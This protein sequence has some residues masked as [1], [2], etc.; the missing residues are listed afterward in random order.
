[1]HD[2][3]HHALEAMPAGGEELEGVERLTLRSVGIDIGSSTTHAGF[4]E[5]TLRREGRHSARFIVAG[6]RELYRSPII[7]TPYLSGTRIDAESVITFVAGCYRAA[8]IAPDAVDTGA[9]VITGEALKKEN[10]RPILEH[11]AREGGRFVCASAGPMHEA[12]LAAHGSGAVAL[13]RHHRNAVLNVDIG[14]GTTK[15]S[16]VRAGRIERMMAIEIGA[17]LVAFDADMRITRL[18]QPGRTILAALG[19]AAEVG[20]S[21]APQQGR[22]LAEKMADLLFEAIIG[23]R[24]DA[25]AEQLMLSDSQ[26]GRPIGGIDHLVFSGG[27]AEYVY[28]RE[29]ESFGDLGPWLGA[30]LRD[31]AR[32]RLAQGVL[33]GATEGIRATVIGAGQYTLQASGTTSSIAAPAALPAHGLQVVH[34]AIDKRQ[35]TSEI[36]MALAA[37]LGRYDAD[38]IGGEMALALTI[39]GQPDYPYIRR[40]AEAIQALA[41]GEAMEPLFVVLDQDIAKSLGSILVEEL[42]LPRPAVILDG[43]EAADLDYLDIGRPLGT[44]EV[45]PVTVKSLIFGLRSKSG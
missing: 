20:Q 17:R 29:T 32:L 22:A 42:R 21:L 37:A 18:E 6:R 25:L 33:I 24:A 13:S 4:S 39:L 30:A 27:V 5:L 28:G 26:P 9:V 10:A 23:G 43:I 41:A 7:L 19:Q 15:I 8:A 31:E 1:M 35:S 34:A 36:C 16:V 44:S 14:G 40:I 38:R 2:E 45:V 11:F 3:D 12:L